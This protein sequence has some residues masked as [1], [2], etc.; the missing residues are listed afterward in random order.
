MPRVRSARFS[1]LRS[2]ARTN[3]FCSGETTKQTHTQM[4]AAAPLAHA[5]MPAP[6]PQYPLSE[7]L[8]KQLVA[9]DVL[10]R[11]Q[12]SGA[13]PDSPF[14]SRYAPPVTIADYAGRIVKYCLCGE[15]IVKVAVVLMLRY[16]RA[17][18]QNVSVSN[19]HR[20]LLTAIVIAIK[21]SQDVYYANGYYAKVG[22]IQLHELNALEQ[23][24]VTG[25]KFSTHVS[26]DE[27]VPLEAALT[28]AV[29]TLPTAAAVAKATRAAARAFVR[30][31]ASFAAPP[32]D[33]PLTDSE[34]GSVVSCEDTHSPTGVSLQLGDSLDV[35]VSPASLLVSSG[36]NGRSAT[37]PAAPRAASDVHFSF[38]EG[39]LRAT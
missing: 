5:C 28:R 20:L 34:E 35:A 12:S 11:S 30:V 13:P 7:R 2:T 26:R 6:A 32:D 15:D 8:Y 38:A 24:F 1:F 25:L 21:M 37:T 29:T 16:C 4:A 33:E 27:I 10:A 9:I 23:A 36:L 18:N 39:S 31:P 17:T 19:V 14:R 3:F 22:G